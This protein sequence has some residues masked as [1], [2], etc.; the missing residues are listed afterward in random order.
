MASIIKRGP[1]QY[2]AKVRRQGFPVRSKTF[3]T[4]AEAKSWADVLEGKISGDEYVDRSRE[5]RT[6]L[7][8]LLRRYLSDVT[9]T[10]KGE[11][12][13]RYRIAKLL[14]HDIVTLPVT[15]VEP[16]DIAKL[17]D[18]RRADG[19]AAST[20]RNEMNLLS[21]VF[22]LAAA[23]WGYRIGNPVAGVARP[24]Q[25]KARWATLSPAQEE[26][27]LAE[28]RKRRQ[29]WVYH[30]VRLALTTAARAGEIRGLRFENIRL[31]QHHYV[32][33]QEGKNGEARVLSL[34]HDM[35][36]A[37]REML[38]AVPIRRLDGWVFGDPLAK[39]ADGGFPVSVL[40]DAFGRV[41]AR[42]GMPDLRFHD[43]RHIAT[44]RL[45]LIHRD[46]L[47]L[48]TTTGHRDLSMLR[49][50]LNENPSER[51]AELRRREAEIR[52]RNLV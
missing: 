30:C 47:D 18:E 46:A 17:R 28:C 48:A 23:E 13:E 6:T 25:P 52:N 32:Q 3:E 29:W 42:A 9:P 31:D 26:V 36:I 12:S 27:L 40:S 8:E 39:V 49:R 7:A 41:A 10:K 5:Q 15:S 22:K 24:K 38:D 45:A 19:R 34:T 44:T 16:S 43:L 33:L 51:A 2:Q 11:R 21:S 37:F 1:A 35:E 50:Y 14:R 4:H 20:V